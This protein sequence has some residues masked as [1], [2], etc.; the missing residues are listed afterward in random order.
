MSFTSE[1]REQ[2]KLQETGFLQQSFYLHPNLT[3]KPGF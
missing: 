1:E 3:K 2:P